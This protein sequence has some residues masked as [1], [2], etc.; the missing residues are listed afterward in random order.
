MHPTQQL[1]PIKEIKDGIV[2]L[3]N[4]EWRAVLIASSMNFAL[5]SPEEQ[6]AVI[7]QY[8]NF[9]NSLDFN[10]QILVES[11][12]LN[13]RG[14]LRAL[15]EIEEKQA[16]EL[17]RV[18]AKEYREFIKSLSEMVN[19]MSKNF[20]IVIP[21]YPLAVGKKK[22]G[23]EDFARYKTQ[24]TQ[25]VE[26]VIAGLRRTGV[27]TVRLGSSEIVELLWSYFNPADLEKGEIPAFPPIE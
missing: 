23:V 9:L 21:F 17:L 25:R 11:R 14:Y 6:E 26:Y 13:I 18:Q 10:I 20:Y 2:I 24:I 8:Q 16:T 19:L 22:L 4:G 7:Y 15:Q 12:K 27:H 3:K 1:I 5:L